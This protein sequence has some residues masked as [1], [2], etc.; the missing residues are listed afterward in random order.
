L[1]ANEFDELLKIQRMMATRIVEETS[2]D[3]KIKLLDII[4]DLVTPANKKVQV[5]QVIIEAETQGLTESEV[6]RLLDELKKDHL[7]VEP[8]T[9]FI[10]KT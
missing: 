2:V 1:D 5:E 8:E 7:I 10:Q 4:N 6:M 3:N 9:G